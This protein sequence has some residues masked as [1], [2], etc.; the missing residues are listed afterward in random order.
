MPARRALP[1]RSRV[2]HTAIPFG[3][4]ALRPYVA[5]LAGGAPGREREKCGGSARLRTHMLVI[6]AVAVTS[7]FAKRSCAVSPTRII[8]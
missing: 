4:I 8:I 7:P 6:L 2:V 5:A 1:P 3:D